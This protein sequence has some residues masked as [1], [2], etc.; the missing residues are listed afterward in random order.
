MLWVSELT[1]A[2]WPPCADVLDSAVRHLAFIYI[3]GENCH[4][5][6]TR[7]TR[8][9]LLPGLVL[10]SRPKKCVRQGFLKRPG[11]CLVG[12]LCFSGSFTNERSEE[13]TSEL[14]SHLNLVCRLL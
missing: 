11:F 10:F 3:Y 13:H 5:S 9:P 7:V 8:R 14:Q 1:V 12:Y 4:I 2:R 6:L